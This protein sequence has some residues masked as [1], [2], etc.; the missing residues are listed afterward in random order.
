VNTVAPG[1]V[2]TDMLAPYAAHRVAI[3]K[4]IPVGRFAAPE[5]VAGLVA[6]LLSPAATYMTG[7][8]LPVDGGLSAMAGVHR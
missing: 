7:A 1:F 3:E 4:Q 8:V 5:E 2:D 6:F